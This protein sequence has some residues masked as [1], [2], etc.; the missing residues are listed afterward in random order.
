M[1]EETNAQASDMQDRRQL[2][3]TWPWFLLNV[4]L[5]PAPAHFTLLRIKDFR[6]GKSVLHLIVTFLLAF[7]LLAAGY[8]QLKF[9]GFGRLWMLLPILSGLIVLFANLSSKENYKNFDISS[10]T[11]THLPFFLFLVGMFTVMSVLPY[12]DLIE[13]DRTQMM[14]YKAWFLDLP[15]WQDLLILVAGLVLL[16]AG[17][18]TNTEKPVSIN[19]AFILYACF[20]VIVALLSAV[21][22][23]VFDW[24]KVQGGFGAQ[25][26]IVLIGAVLALDYWDAETFGQY[27]RRIFF[28]TSTKAVYFVLLWLCFLGLPQKAASDLSAYYFKEARPPVMEDFQKHLVFSSRDRFKSA[29]DAS[30]KVRALYARALNSSKAGE[31]Q[32]VAGL[33]DKNKESIFPPDAD[34]CRLAD[35]VNRKEMHAASPALEKV[36]IFRPVHS[37]WDV[38]LTALL[39]QG[40][41]SN[42][43]LNNFI[44]DFKAKLPKTSQGNLPAINTPSKA[45]YVSLATATCV[46]FI[47]PRYEL[48][49]K[50]AANSFCPVIYLR[51]A[52]KNYWAALFHVDRQTG[53]A[54]FRI[55]THQEMEKSIQVL[56]DS[57]KSGAFR[58]EILSR[59]LVPISLDYLREVLDHYSG[60]VVVFTRSGLAQALP[61]LFAAND[62]AE[63]QRAVNFAASPVL[64]GGMIVAGTRIS[65]Y[66]D[67][68]RFVAIIKEMLTPAPYRQNLFFTQGAAPDGFKGLNRLKLIETLLSQMEPLR[69]CDRFD[70]AALLVENNHVNGAPDLF[71]K[72]T[73][74]TPISSDLIDC[75]EA[76]RI[77][78]K[79][80]LL[81][82]HEKAYGYL[83]L[84]F[85]RH[86]FDS[87][88]ELWYH[89]AGEKLKKP[90][91]P[92]Y[93]PPDH[94]PDLDLYYRTLADMRNGNR[95]GALKRLE[96]GLEKDSHDS[97]A[98]HLLNK[99]F[100]RPLDERHFFPAQ[101]GL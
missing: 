51:L 30:H 78:R 9:P 17:Y 84:A 38:M 10:V 59:L 64:L 27:M 95:Q 29:H 73:G 25:L 42:A 82:F 70:I 5:F 99:Y 81:G 26:I 47:P 74:K 52:G 58:D 60:A 32:Q 91:A 55:E 16:L 83:E 96:R 75:R 35:L 92:F 21:L 18:I 61:G 80:F 6:F 40:L 1:A 4:I 15:Y 22:L 20:S 44:A 19:R 66:A 63:M 41:I 87:E 69:D 67:Y 45:R 53:I 101:E 37:E 2:R 12:L 57:N 3:G 65:G 11:S 48:L 86:P 54:W 76:F 24:L 62:L 72:L 79:L 13:L 28:L 14:I 50:L 23:F 46:D 8:F 36:P 49:E 31:L 39:M 90:S 71:V 34:I 93:S 88:Y 68:L 7:V 94:K 77:G 89:I 97:L 98:A 43:G 33:F 56:F 85:L 100:N